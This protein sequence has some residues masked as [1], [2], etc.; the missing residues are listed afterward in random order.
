MEKSTV[1]IKSKTK[2]IKYKVNQ[3][4]EN[5]ERKN[6]NNEMKNLLCFKCVSNM[7]TALLKVLVTMSITMETENGSCLL[8]Y[9]ILYFAKIY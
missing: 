6:V 5:R 9:G 2:I 1:R 8:I 7:K 4:N 3:L